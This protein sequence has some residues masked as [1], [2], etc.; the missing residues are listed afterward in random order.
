[1]PNTAA[2]GILV[3]P[4][5]PWHLVSPQLVREPSCRFPGGGWEER[6][7]DKEIVLYYGLNMLKIV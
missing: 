3:L 2:A 1:L 7:Q 4:L 5:P 6:H